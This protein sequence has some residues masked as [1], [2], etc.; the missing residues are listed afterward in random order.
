MKTLTEYLTVVFKLNAVPVFAFCYIIICLYLK[1]GYG[2]EQ[3]LREL[4]VKFETEDHDIVIWI[5]CRLPSC[6]RCMYF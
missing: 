2:K 5:W 1:S 3:E 4:C 6:N